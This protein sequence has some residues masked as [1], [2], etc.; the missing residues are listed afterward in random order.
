M[1][2][3]QFENLTAEQKDAM[4]EVYSRPIHGEPNPLS[5]E[6]FIESATPPAGT[7]APYVFLPWA[8]MWLGI[9]PDGYTHS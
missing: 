1:T 2:N 3:A 9:E 6:G 5:W 4:W 8:G 7:F